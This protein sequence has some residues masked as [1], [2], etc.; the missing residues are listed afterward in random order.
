MIQ[1]CKGKE[2]AQCA[3]EQGAYLPLHP[4][5]GDSPLWD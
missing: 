4:N 5:M 1:Y 2:T 3:L